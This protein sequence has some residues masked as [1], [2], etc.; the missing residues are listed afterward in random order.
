MDIYIGLYLAGSMLGGGLAS[1]IFFEDK[2][3]SKMARIGLTVICC[4][5]SWWGVGVLLGTA[6]D[7][8]CDKP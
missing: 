2:K 6:L 8:L 1:G 4:L 3:T 5:M 7:D